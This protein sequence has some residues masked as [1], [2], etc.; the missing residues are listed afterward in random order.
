MVRTK[1]LKAGMD[2]AAVN[3]FRASLIWQKAHQFVLSVYNYS[4]YFPQKEASALTSQFRRAAIAIALNTAEALRQS[5]DQK[6]G[7]LKL[8][9]DSIEQCR[10]YLILAKDL[11]YGDHPELMPQ[12]EEVSRMLEQ[13][14]IPPSDL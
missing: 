12:L 2:K 10:Y 9:R 3:D 6:A 13:L 1:K 8:A 5:N 7:S 14:I 11:G 4:D